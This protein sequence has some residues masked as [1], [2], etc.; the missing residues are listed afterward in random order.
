MSDRIGHGS[1]Q[2][3]F[4]VPAPHPCPIDHNIDWSGL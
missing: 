4:F 3:D 2:F 1:V